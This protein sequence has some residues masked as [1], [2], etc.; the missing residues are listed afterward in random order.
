MDTTL[1]YAYGIESFEDLT[2]ERIADL[3]AHTVAATV[4]VRL[5]SLTSLA[6]TWEHQWRPNDARLDRVTLV[7]VQG[8]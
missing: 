2:A 6:A 1:T 4:Q 7:A 5:P 3:A 8:F